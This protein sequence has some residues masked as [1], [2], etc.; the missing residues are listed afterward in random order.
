M[1]RLQLGGQPIPVKQWWML[2][3]VDSMKKGTDTR[4]SANREVV[5]KLLESVLEDTM[6]MD[7]AAEKKIEWNGTEWTAE[8]SENAA[9]VKEVLWELSELNF[10]YELFALDVRLT[11]KERLTQ[12]L[13]AVGN[14]QDSFYR[15]SPANVDTGL[16]STDMDS[17]L[18]RLRS[19]HELMSE[20]KVGVEIEPGERLEETV[21][22]FYCQCFFDS[23]GRSPILPRGLV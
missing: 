14:E 17:R 19:L 9:L 2:L 12:I 13:A 8:S 16:V 1:V 10:R 4:A 6:T 23:F 5:E 15:V 11:G 3:N 18:K 20:W 21:A 22:S 7:A